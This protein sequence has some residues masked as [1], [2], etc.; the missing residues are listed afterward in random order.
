ML[1]SP[2]Q[3]AGNQAMSAVKRYYETLDSV[4]TNP[5]ADLSVLNGVSVQPMTETLIRSVEMMRAEG[6]VVSGSRG[7]V[8]VSVIGTVAPKDEQGVPVP[9]EASADLRVCL[10]WSDYSAI[11][12]DGGAVTADRPTMTLAKP[13]LVNSS[14]PDPGGWKVSWDLQTSVLVGYQSCDE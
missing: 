8:A 14:W 10:D 4:E 7:V 5:A 1:Q 13:T 11:R 12:P 3:Q 6:V 2:E 9:G